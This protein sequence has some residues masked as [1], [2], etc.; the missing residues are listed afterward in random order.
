MEKQILIFRRRADRQ[1]RLRSA[2]IYRRET[3]SARQI[4]PQGDQPAVFIIHIKIPHI[5]GCRTPVILKILRVSGCG[6]P[7]LLQIR[8][9]GNRL[10]FHPRGIQYRKQNTRKNRT[11]SHRQQK[12]HKRE[13]PDFSTKI[14]GTGKTFKRIFHG[15]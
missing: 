4:R 12:F 10:R 6:D 1:T 2:G 9:A 13:L 7:D 3:F 5:R 11:H 15:C 14:P 8:K